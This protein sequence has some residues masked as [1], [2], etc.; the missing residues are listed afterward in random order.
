MSGEAARSPVLVL[1]GRVCSDVFG[2]VP[3]GGEDCLGWLPPELKVKTGLGDP[4]SSYCGGLSLL[5]GLLGQYNVTLVE[6]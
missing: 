4:H 6:P 5:L 1:S 2:L 3:T